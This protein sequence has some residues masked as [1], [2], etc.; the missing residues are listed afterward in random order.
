MRTSTFPT[1]L[2]ALAAVAAA[3]STAC[4]APAGDPP[5]DAQ[6]LE[7]PALE[8]ALASVPEPFV[9]AENDGATLRFSTTHA[10]GGEVVVEIAD[11]EYGLNLQAE[12][13]QRGDAFR[14][15]PGGEYNGSR[16]LGTPWGPAFYSRGSYD[17]AAGRE[18]Q[19][20]IF[21]LHPGGDSRLLT[22]IYTYPPG[23][24]QTRVNELLA[25]LGE[26][27]PLTPQEG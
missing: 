27:E 9:V 1:T 26:I 5:E 6:R 25:L 2:A 16:E 12:V 18:E 17:A 3:L 24:G 4:G 23:E 11:P 22:L 10:T 14:A 8:L 15:M 7:N 21:A 19:T 20:W 13:V